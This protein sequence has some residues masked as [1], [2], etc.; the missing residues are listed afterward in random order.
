[1]SWSR[2]ARTF[3]ELEPEERDLVDDFHDYVLPLV[4]RAQ[5][6]KDLPAVAVGKQTSGVLADVRQADP[7]LRRYLRTFLE[8]WNRKLG[9]SGELTWRVITAPRVPM[10]AV[11]FETVE[12]GG[13]PP[14]PDV[15]SPEWE[16]VLRRYSTVADRP[17]TAAVS[18]QGV[19]RAVTDT[20]IILLKRG[21]ILSWTA[22]AALDDAEATMAQAMRLAGG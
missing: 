21:D 8:E 2:W 22:S 18:R 15:D 19:I 13:S 17:V 6:W 12:P 16:E 4:G 14:I 20:A 5:A 10:L 1:M 7:T 9:D 3:F 11:V